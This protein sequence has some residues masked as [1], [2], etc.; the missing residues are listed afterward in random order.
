MQLLSFLSSEARLGRLILCILNKVFLILIF[1]F[2]DQRS[3]STL[4]TGCCFESSRLDGIQRIEVG[5]LN[6]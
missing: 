5:S 3:T 2:F 1:D 4:L 6:Y